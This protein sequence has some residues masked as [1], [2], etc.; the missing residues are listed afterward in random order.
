VRRVRALALAAALTISAGVASAQTPPI[1]PAVSPAPV[2]VM[3]FVVDAAPGT[4]GLA[5]APFW[6]GE[7]ASIAL[8]DGLAAQ[9]VA[10]MS[11]ADRVSAFEQLQL[12]ASGS[13]TRATLI[14]AGEMIGASAIVVGEVKLTDR[15]QVRARVIDLASGRQFPDVTADGASNAFFDILDRVGKGLV[16]SL[17]HSAV[18]PPPPDR[19]DIA[20]FE[21]YVKGLVA[22]SPETQLRFLEAALAHSPTD[23]R[24]LLALWEV[25]TA[26][27]D[28]TRALEAASRVPAT[29]HLSREARF[30]SAQSLMAL[31]RYE[32]SFAVLDTLYKEKPAAAISN[33]LGVLQLRRGPQAPGGSPAFFFNRA[34]DEGHTDPDIAF[35]LGYAYAN[36]ADISSAIYWLREAVRR[37]PADGD[38]HRVLSAML[39]AQAKTVEAQREFDLAKVL[40]S[41]DTGTAPD[42]TVPK[43]LERLL[44]EL[45]P[46][47][48]WRH[49]LVGVA[50][51]EQTAA[52]YVDRAKRLSDEMRDR[53]A[54]DELRRAIYVSPYFDR[55]HIMLGRIYQR[56]G[57][58]T[59]ASEEYSV[60]LWCQETAEAHAALASVELAMG[61]RDLARDSATRALA[62]DP[63]N[64]EAKEVLRQLGLPP[65]TGVLKSA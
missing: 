26:Q 42:K 61:K 5:G 13:L 37:D 7:A 24:A 58:L 8:G 57:R 60:A 40:G 36:V 46:P 15:M 27:G 33:A 52:F 39:V 51:Q 47:F 59:D 22:T 21:D 56:T 1:A 31:K 10:S 49:L 16:V 9:G 25:R 30:L 35:N 45:A 20:S 63:A 43:G 14:R 6:M 11:R 41:V 64:A 32:E 65:A 4:S 29:S 53:E 44:P 17:P 19:L 18:P 54:I 3:P 50:D 62:I 48:D 55:P 12:P 38:A 28:H 23:A 34:V 2:L